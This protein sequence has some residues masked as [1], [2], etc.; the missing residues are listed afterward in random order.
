[1]RVAGFDWHAGNSAKCE[2]H[3]VVRAEIEAVFRSDRLATRPDFAHS[4]VEERFL[5]IGPD[6]SG[7]YMFVVFTLRV[8]DGTT[9][10]RP[11]SARYMHRK[12]LKRY[13][14]ENPEL[15]D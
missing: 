5:A 12:E 14:E 13:V 6:R 7:R 1:M 3:G 2:K 8:R 15:P 11:I 10:I 4:D 9:W